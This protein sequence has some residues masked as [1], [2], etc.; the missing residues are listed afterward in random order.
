MEDT[1]TSSPKPTQAK[2]IHYQ[3]LQAFKY[4]Q[5]FNLFL[6][7]RDN[8]G[9][10]SFLLFKTPESSS[11]SHFHGDFTKHDPAIFYA[12]AREFIT[13]TAGLLCSQN[14]QYFRAINPLPLNTEK[15]VLEKSQG[16]PVRPQKGFIPAINDICKLL[17]ET[18]YIFQDQTG[19]VTYFIEIPALN[20]D[21]VHNI[22]QDRDIP[23]QFQYYT[24]RDIV[25]AEEE[26]IHPALRACL[27]N[28]KLSSYLNVYILEG[29][30]VEITERYAMI[31]CEP[32][33]TTYM[34]HSL[35]YSMFKKHG[36]H[37]R[38][39]KAFEGEFP[40]D[41]EL[42]NL[43]GIIIPGSGN[44]AYDTT[45]P[46]YKELFECIRKINKVYT[47]INLLGICFGAQASAQA[48]G[49]RVEKMKRSFIRGGEVLRTN[50]A[51]YELEYVRELGLDLEKA[52]VIA[53]AHGDH[54]VE[55]PEGAI[56]QASSINT[57]VE[58]Y[59]I[60]TNLLAFQGHPDYNEPWTAG[61]NFRV[62]QLSVVD[63]DKYAE[64]FIKEKFPEQLTHRVIVEICYKFLKK[65]AVVEKLRELKV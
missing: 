45:V 65:D 3:E 17:T 2:P 6:F 41:E 58:V 28:E 27:K 31:C 38:F 57:N 16:V 11:F 60:G 51:F 61:A 56:N 19:T 8:K 59:T 24:L 20:L 15:L 54:I 29:K 18:P 35:H 48:L 13:H 44:A 1:K 52:L 47:H 55:L 4:F 43:K 33:A 10:P 37:W 5:K 30:E 64:E 32:K 46:W 50:P 14:F 53:E 22:A 49:G 26:L 36:E 7:S 9:N 39:F 40:T 62:N 21:T 12:I 25:H 42:K 34:I 23:V 63:Y